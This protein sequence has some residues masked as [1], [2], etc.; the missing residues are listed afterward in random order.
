[1]ISHH[2]RPKYQQLLSNNKIASTV[3][4]RGRLDMVSEICQYLTKICDLK[5]SELILVYFSLEL[6]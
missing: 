3:S 5:M 4:L 2:H 1:M 6:R